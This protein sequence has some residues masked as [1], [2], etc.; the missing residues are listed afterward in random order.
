LTL[1]GAD[2][3]EYISVGYFEGVISYLVKESVALVKYFELIWLLS[4]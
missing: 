4:H 3:K 1:G 2:G